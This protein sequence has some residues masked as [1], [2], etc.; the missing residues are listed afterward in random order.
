V[1]SKSHTGHAEFFETVCRTP[2]EEQ[3]ALDDFY[4]FKEGEVDFYDQYESVPIEGKAGSVFLWDSRTAHMVW[5]CC[6]FFF[7]LI[8]W[9]WLNST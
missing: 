6:P 5:P 3:A 9:P 7:A 2:L 8:R 1:K 4:M